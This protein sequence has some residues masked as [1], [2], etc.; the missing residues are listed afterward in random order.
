MKNI[1]ETL[2]NTIRGC[3][4]PVEVLPHPSGDGQILIL[5]D[6]DSWR[7]SLDAGPKRTVARHVFADLEDFC[8]YVARRLS[9]DRCE[10]LVHGDGMLVTAFKDVHRADLDSRASCRT[11]TH[12]AFAAWRSMDIWCTQQQVVEHLR[13]FGDYLV[14]DGAQAWLIST[15][16]QLALTAKAEW[17]SEVDSHGRIV[18]Q[19]QS[20]KEAMSTK[21]PTSVEIS[22]PIFRGVL[23]DDIEPTYVMELLISMDKDVKG[24][25]LFRFS[26]P[27]LSLVT[28]EAFGDV[29]RCLR[30]RLPDVLIGRGEPKTEEV[31]AL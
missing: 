20:S 11:T 2:I 12:P 15:F 25:P 13:G 31:P 23:V 24:R 29:V 4:K 7:S 30:E 27:R 22:V 18:V 5:R 26:C 19:S 21:L 8:T 1:L 16:Q 28:H 14:G 6:G 9:G 17:I 10:V 3:H